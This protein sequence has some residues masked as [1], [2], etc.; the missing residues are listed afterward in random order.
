[1]GTPLPLNPYHLPS[2]GPLGLGTYQVGT[3][4][5]FFILTFILTFIKSFLWFEL[6]QKCYK[7]V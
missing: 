2:L 4:L 7:V 6:L 5:I 1:M 3:L